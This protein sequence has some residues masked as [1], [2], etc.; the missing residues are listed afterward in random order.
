MKR[1]LLL[2]M[3]IASIGII[4]NADNY[5]INVGGVEVTTSN[6]NNVTGGDITVTSG[7][8]SGYVRF[9]P[10]TKT[11][12]L[13]NIT[14][15]RTGN[16]NYGVH[17]RKYDNLTIEFIGICKLKPSN[18]PGLKIQR[19]TTV[20]I[21]GT[22]NYTYIYGCS[23][24]DKP[25]IEVDN[26]R[27]L[28]FTGDRGTMDENW[29]LL[30]IKGGG[31]SSTNPTIKG[32]SN[33]TFKGNTNVS[34]DWTGTG[35]SGYCFYN[36]SLTFDTGCDVV[37]YGGDQGVMY[38]CNS[39]TISGYQTIITPLQGNKI[40]TF[41]S[42]AIWNS[43]G[44][45]AN[46]ARI[47]NH[48]VA[49][50]NSNYFPD[51]KFLEAIDGLT[52][53]GSSGYLFHWDG[54]L[55]DYTV[56][57]VTS[58]NISNKNISNISGIQYFTALTSLNCSGNNISSFNLSPLT[59]LITLDCHSNSLTTLGTLPSSLQTLNCSYNNFSGT[60]SFTNNSTLKTL[61]LS[62]NTRLTTVNVYGNSNLTSLD[63]TGCS[64]MT[65]LNCYS[66]KLSSLNLSGCSSLDYVNASNNQLTSL[67]NVP[68]SLQSLYC[69]TNKFSTFSLTGHSKL[70]NLDLGS[71]DNLTSVN[72]QNNS[73]LTNL[74]VNNCSVLS[75]L[76][77]GSCNIS[78]LV[79]TGCSSLY[80]LDCSNNKLSSLNISDNHAL[81]NVYAYNNLITSVPTFGVYNQITLEVLNLSG[82]KFTQVNLNGF[83]KLYNL[84]LNGNANLSNVE[85]NNSAITTL[86]LMS[87]PALTTLKCNN[88]KLSYITYSSS[89]VDGLKLYGTTGITYL[90]CYLNQFTSLDVSKLTNLTYLYCYNNKIQS[91]NVANKTK[92][93]ELEVY[94]NQLTSLNVE[95]CSALKYL[96]CYNNYLS[97]LSVQG[98]N[99]LTL[100]DCSKNQ[101]KEWGMNTLVNSL[102]TIPS[103]SSGNLN[104]ISNSNEG[105]IITDAQVRTARNKRWFP[106]KYV[107]GSGWVDIPVNTSVPGDVN[108]DGTVTAAD[109]TALYD[110][111]L[112]NDYSQI[113]NGDQTGDGIITAADITAVY[114]I[115]LSSK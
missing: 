97:S 5:E 9:T 83:S 81:K 95:G 2:M 98:C 77:C 20:K 92:L 88:D 74:Y 90:S 50:L 91:L 4:A 25:A 107:S 89:A 63:V 61:N 57:L 99:S 96:E 111:L 11:L 105:N 80:Y 51:S 78:T 72:V 41:S 76:K 23:S 40:G 68:A 13:Y 86:E 56:P 52:A 110:V 38:G 33:I 106:K 70:R 85:V 73:A 115:M 59:K 21:S 27:T 55:M 94:N 71:N 103:G 32:G 87:C 19:N 101:I 54:C 112:N 108:G 35:S 84:A 6:Y 45:R 26:D 104:V 82:N 37:M 49:I 109:I 113:V 65:T 16:N 114:T 18:A 36:Q 58:L 67:S 30:E 7:C 10:S 22:H 17:N 60:I 102:R 53:P 28:T 8:S 93:Y 75:V 69:L 62:S 1:I 64:G 100:I 66:S 43:N 42:G 48:H 44:Q 31:S 12:T 15:E 14:I 3:A 24:N 34:I 39:T 47:T 46:R 29:N 79:F